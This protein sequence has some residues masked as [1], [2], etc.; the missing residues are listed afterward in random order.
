MDWLDEFDINYAKSNPQLDD[1]APTLGGELSKTTAKFKDNPEAMGAPKSAKGKDWL[2][3]FDASYSPKQ[4]QKQTDKDEILAM[5]RI[6]DTPKALLEGGA[7]LLTGLV[8]SAAGGLRG[9]YTGATG[10]DLNQ[11]VANIQ[12]TQNALTYQPTTEKGQKVVE[13]AAAPIEYGAKGAGYVGEKLGR[14]VGGEQGAIAGESIGQASVPIAATLLMGRSGLKAAENVQAP[15]APNIPVVSSVV[16]GIKDVVKTKSAAGKYALAQEYLQKMTTPAEASKI[17]TALEQGKEIVPNSPVTAADA[18]AQANRATLISGRPDR[19]GSQYV[20][21]QEGLSKLPETSAELV[22]LKL[23]QEYARNKVLET[24]AGS[25]VVYSKAADI[26]KANANKN[27]STLNGEKL[28]ADSELSNLLNRPSMEVATSIAQSL[29]KEKGETFQLAKSI[30]EQVVEKYNPL[31]MTKD[32]VVIP[33]QFAEYNAQSL[34]Y[35]KLALD[36]MIAKP[37]EYGIT[38]AQKSAISKTRASLINWLENKSAVYENANKAYAIDS[39][40]LQQM[41]LWRLLKDKYQAPTGKESPGVYLR[42]LRDETKAVKEATG[43]TKSS[44]FNDIFDTRQSVLANRLATEMENNVVKTRMAGEVTN[45]NVG[46]PTAGI[47]PTLPNMLMREAMV[48][49]FILKNLAQK[50]NVDVNIAAARILADP[51]LLA[52]TLKQVTAPHRPTLLK[53]FKEAAANKNTLT[54]SAVTANQQQQQ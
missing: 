9:L 16:K 34:Q 31:T 47:E 8:G 17:I 7:S 14:V 10:G 2:A 54:L 24:E 28:V 51:Q 20:S 19:F 13:F 52:N 36:K 5:T 6:G 15:G 1:Y 32:K 12:E 33:E 40:P 30:P 44:S 18:I 22:K 25:D 45:P 48:A 38:S 23:Q 3:E 46:S 43:W 41:D 42:L 35:M 4:K 27:Y 26:R 37:A 29:A 39:V 50:A 49:N 53:F 11:I 21:L